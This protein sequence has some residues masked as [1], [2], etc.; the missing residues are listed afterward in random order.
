MNALVLAVLTSAVPAAAQTT[1]TTPTL[2]TTA[3]VVRV[4]AGQIG[5][6]P[7]ARLQQ[8]FAQGAVPA[9]EQLEGTF[10]GYCY[11]WHRPHELEMTVFRGE[12]DNVTPDH[13][14]AFPAPRREFR[15][16]IQD[17]PLQSGAD[18][19]RGV[20]APREQG[21]SWVY[22]TA[23]AQDRIRRYELRWW[24]GKTPEGEDASWI[25]HRT[26]ATRS[27]RG[28]TQRP[29]Q[30]LRMCYFFQRHARR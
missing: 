3:A 23:R 24:Q 6:S 11:E 12:E 19:F 5:Q 28:L 4:A 16:F 15:A 7:F 26:V 18:Y 9:R 20:T 22:E 21:G 10:T 17:D 27:V 25:M 29:G 1:Q 30:V 2:E 14:P 13:G 8:L